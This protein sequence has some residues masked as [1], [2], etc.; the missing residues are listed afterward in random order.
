[1]ASSL[2]PPVPSPR[3]LE[4]LQLPLLTTNH[5]YCHPAQSLCGGLACAAVPLC[6]Q[7]KLHKLLFNYYWH[8]PSRTVAQSHSCPVAHLPIF[9]VAISIPQTD[10]RR[11]AQTLPCETIFCCGCSNCPQVVTIFSTHTHTDIHTAEC[12]CGVFIWEC[13]CWSQKLEPRMIAVN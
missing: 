3:P 8:W 2:S 4:T 7:I 1:M 10:P 13:V 11:L 12:H 9:L 5:I 6:N